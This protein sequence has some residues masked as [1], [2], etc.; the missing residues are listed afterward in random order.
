MHIW[1]DCIPCILKMSLELARLSMKEEGQVS[2]FMSEILAMPGL[3]GKEWHI[4]APEIVGKVVA[5][6]AQLT[7]EPD[8]FKEIKAEQNRKALDLYE[9]ARGRVEGSRDPYLT[10]LKLAI[11]GNSI[12]AMVGVTEDPSD[13]QFDDHASLTCEAAEGLRNRI[14]KADKIVYL[15]DNCGEIVFDRLFLEVLQEGRD[16]NITLVA[17]SMPVLNDATP[18]EATSVGLDKVAPVVGNGIA[19]PFPGT[20]LNLVSDEVAELISR[21]DL[22]ISKGVGNLDSLT[23]DQQELKGR[24]S[25]LFHGK[26]RPCCAPRMV[27]QGT[28]VVDNC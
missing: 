3:R 21:A 26:C 20:R 7:N 9:R 24:V 18:K 12:D 28:L 14:K 2:A 15:L 27:P 19:V 17:R 23:E 6:F 16:L 4:T 10:A 25:F 22:I 8:P 13:S 5:R 1:P 11:S